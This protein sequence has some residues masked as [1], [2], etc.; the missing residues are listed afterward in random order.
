[1]RSST[2][3]AGTFMCGANPLLIADM[4]DWKSWAMLG[5]RRDD[6]NRFRGVA[7]IIANAQFTA[8]SKL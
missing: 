6:A 7:D 3:S 5:Y 4:G 2:T 8:P 1:M